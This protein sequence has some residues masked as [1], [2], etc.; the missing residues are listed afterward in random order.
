[1][2]V[3]VFSDS[4]FLMNVTPA[5]SEGN[6]YLLKHALFVKQASQFAFDLRLVRTLR[7]CNEM[8][9]IESFMRQLD[10]ICETL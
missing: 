9:S 2:M 6:L 7:K 4:E 5:N 10:Q 1:M 8:V 3:L